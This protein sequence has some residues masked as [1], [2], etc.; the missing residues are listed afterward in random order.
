MHLT[1][2]RGLIRLSNCAGLSRLGFNPSTR[3]Y[4]AYFVVVGNQAGLYHRLE[5]YLGKIEVLH[6]EYIL[7]WIQLKN[8]IFLNHAFA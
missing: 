7:R 6:K 4:D 1:Y 5:T 8:T 3:P 2:T